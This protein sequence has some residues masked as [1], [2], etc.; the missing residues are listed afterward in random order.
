MARIDP[1]TPAVDR[2]PGAPMLAVMTVDEA[3]RCLAELGNPARLE[4]YRLLV[5]AGREGLTVGQIQRHL[6][7]PASTLSHHIA[8]LVGAGLI[9]QVREGRTQ[10]CHA[11]YDR[12]DTL[13]DFLTRE[14]CQG[15]ASAEAG[16][17]VETLDR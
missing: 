17:S 13:L 5:R 16:T 14:C 8:H 3:A 7:V 10:R 2:R 9:T 1:R 15:A 12:M 4:A 6:D 11:L